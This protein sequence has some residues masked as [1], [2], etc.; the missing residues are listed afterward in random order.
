MGDATLLHTAYSGQLTVAFLDELM[1]RVRQTIEAPQFASDWDYIQSTAALYT[2]NSAP[3][4]RMFLFSFTLASEEEYRKAVAAELPEP[5]ATFF[6]EQGEPYL[7]KQT[8]TLLHMA[9]DAADEIT[10]TYTHSLRESW[11]NQKIEIPPAPQ[12]EQTF[13]QDKG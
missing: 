6:A 5:D 4:Q 7:L 1:K 12:P 9:F 8:N 2:E 10:E 13:T 3:W 11:I